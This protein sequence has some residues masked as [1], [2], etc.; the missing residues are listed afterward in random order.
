MDPTVI[1]IAAAASSPS[2]APAFDSV[3]SKPAC[4]PLARL[5]HLPPKLLKRH[6]CLI[7]TD[8]RFRAA[9]RLL[10]S[11]HREDA[12]IPIGPHTSIS[13]AKRRRVR[14][15]SRLP[16]AAAAAGRNFISPDVYRLVQRELVLREEG[17]AID[18]DRLFGNLLSSMPLTFNV[19]G[20]LALDLDLATA[21]WRHLLPAFV[22]AV[23]AINFETSPGRG[24]LEYLHDGTAFDAALHIVTPEGEPGL[25]VIEM[26]YSEAMSGPAAA[27]RPRY[28]AASRQVRLF[29]DPDSLALRSVALEQLWREHMLAQLA[30]DLEFTPKAHFVA[31]APHLNR[32]ATAAFHAYADLLAA[33]EPEDTSA[34]GFTP[35]TLEAIVDALATAG[36]TD[37]AAKLRQRY[38]DFGRILDLALTEADGNIPNPPLPS[39]PSSRRHRPSKPVAEPQETV[40]EDRVTPAQRSNA[41]RPNRQTR[42][43]VSDVSVSSKRPALT[44]D[45]RTA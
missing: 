44:T 13:G 30:V 37:T 33:P 6:G 20:P 18:E 24:R 41:R 12:G 9:A 31:I 28:D 8:T 5:P 34:V 36:A 39:A 14:L 27:H 11:L 43:P 2:A 17:A 26:K 19:L 38:L 3:T 45:L 35:L 25:V 22:H 1:E 40:L 23:T 42:R 4:R 7:A 10:Q 29:R 16:F 32:Q 15:G 21:V